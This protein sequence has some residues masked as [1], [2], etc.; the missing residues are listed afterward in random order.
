MEETLRVLNDLEREGVL[1]R[2]AIGGAMGAT[3]YCEP[4]LTFDLDVFVLLPATPSGLL[5]LSPLYY[6]LRKRGFVEEGESVNVEGVPVQFLPVYNT[7]LRESLD[8]AREVLYESTSTRVLRAEH[9][10]AIAVATGRQKDRDR[11]RLLL[12]QA[13]LDREYLTDVLVRHNLQDKWK[14]WI[15]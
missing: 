9:L 3:F 13:N 4:V 8:Q 5:T 12:E 11:V 2:Y 10:A 6:A 15:R 1:T 14:E 7:L